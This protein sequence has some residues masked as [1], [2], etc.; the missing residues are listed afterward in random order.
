MDQ[1]LQESRC[2][3]SVPIGLLG[4]SEESNLAKHQWASTEDSLNI[5][6]AP[7]DCPQKCASCSLGAMQHRRCRIGDR[8]SGFECL[9][10]RDFCSSMELI[11]QSSAKCDATLA[12]LTAVAK[13]S[14]PAFEIAILGTAFWLHHE[15]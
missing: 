13:A 3:V 15:V 1:R 10:H 6:M 2:V 14:A 11:C 12:L 5:D 4:L 7:A 9:M 8:I